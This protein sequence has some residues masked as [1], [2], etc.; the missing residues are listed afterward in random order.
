MVSSRR[1]PSLDA[2]IQEGL[3][4]QQAGDLIGAEVLYRQVLEQDPH[5]PDALHLYGCLASDM[6]RMEDALELMRRAIESN[7]KAH[8]CH[9][10][11][12]NALS[13]VGRLDEAIAHYKEALRLKPDYALAYNNYGLALAMK[14][15]VGKARTCYRNAIKL[16]PGFADPHYNLGLLSKSEGKLDEA[17][18]EYRA[19]I[20]LAPRYADAYYNLGNA[21]AAAQQIQPA[22]DAYQQASRLRPGDARIPTNLGSVYLKS[23]QLD[24]AIASFKRARALDPSDTLSHSNLILAA[25]YA[26]AD[27][28]AMYA[29][30]RQWGMEHGRALRRQDLH[31]ANSAEAGRRLRIGYVSADFRAHAAAYWI[32]PLLA[33][34]D[35]QAMQV[36]C[37]Y[38]HHQN[39]EVTERLKACADTWVECAPL[40]DEALDARIRDDRI[41]I[42]VDLSGHTEGNRLLV[43][44]RQPAPVQVTWFGFP[45]S[46][47]LE[48]IQYRFTDAVIDPA[49]E[50]ECYY[51]EQL[52]HLP[53]FYAAYRPDASMPDVGSG[54]AQKNG[55]V[56]FIS[57]NNLAKITPAALD[58]WA[59][60]LRRLPD[61]RLLLQAGGMEGSE[62]QERITGF[63]AAH[64]IERQRLLLRGWTGLNEYFATGN[65][66]DI[67][68]DSFPFN[69]GVTTCHALWMGLPVISLSGQSAASRVGRSILSHVGLEHLAVQDAGA[70]VEAAVALAGDPSQLQALRESMRE[71]MTSSGFI[72]GKRFA[73]EVEQV[74]RRLWGRW[75]S[76]QGE[77]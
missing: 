57:L 70:Y 11:L 13:R 44:A 73:R 43:F 26:S 1:K 46:S 19:A 24:L 22:V 56:T 65:E 2:E 49:G 18:A 75:C 9:Y 5:H 8:S 31:H 61:A 53:G 37:Y 45:V 10:N 64:G 38:N 69:G 32:E 6:G 62:V 27:P 35:R 17:I 68:L 28:E 42:L 51:S 60:I 66:A 63:F 58:L 15:E 47:G 76:Q 40:S 21:L 25:S 59:Q 20:K 33:G 23:G 34:H 74:Y 12:A 54:P 67:A 30:A 36:F 52:V 4:R 3:R 41:D 39:D 72:D 29:E 55:H 71:R 16:Q 14:G 77:A 7:P 50:N 48:A